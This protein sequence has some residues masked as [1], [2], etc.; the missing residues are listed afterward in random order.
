MTTVKR[1]PAASSPRPGRSHGARLGATGLATARYISKLQGQYRNDNPAGVAAVARLRRGVGKKAFEDPEAWGSGASDGLA[2][3]REDKLNAEKAKEG[4][5]PSPLLSASQRKAKES[6]EL[7]EEEAVHLAV[8]LW[9][10]HQ[11]SVR[12]ADM[13]AP[14]WGI[15]RSVRRLAQGRTG[16][17]GS[18]TDGSGPNGAPRANAEGQ[19]GEGRPEETLNE[20][21]RKRFVRLGTATSFTNLGVRLREVVLLLRQARIPLDYARLAD[22]LR[23]WQDVSRRADIRRS[24]GRDFHASGGHNPRPQPTEEAHSGETDSELAE[25]AYDT[26]E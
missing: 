18:E 9:A 13:H 15:G 8:A 20:A 14:G 12:D 22:E 23:A 26:G 1:S 24:W 17:A 4:A 3:A 5:A 19:A 11:Q 6:A 10:L 25:D 16:A 21:L 2:L 7:A